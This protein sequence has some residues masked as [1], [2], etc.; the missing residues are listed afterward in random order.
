MPYEQRLFYRR[1]SVLCSRAEF[2]KTNEDWDK[3]DILKR[4]VKGDAAETGLIKCY[5]LLH[6]K[7][8]HGTEEL[9]S[10]NPQVANIPFN[11]STKFTASVVDL[12]GTGRYSVMMKGGTENFG[13]V[14]DGKVLS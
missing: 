13:R 9:R 2:I 1:I 4:P 10:K 3:V 7:S 5:E 14:R 6:A 12:N 8:G 11:S